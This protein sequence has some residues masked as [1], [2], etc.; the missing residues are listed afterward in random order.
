MKWSDFSLIQN[1]PMFAPGYSGK[2][3]QKNPEKVS[4]APADES[5]GFPIQHGLRQIYFSY[6]QPLVKGNTPRLKSGQAFRF[7]TNYDI[8]LR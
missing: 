3:K 1:Y 8:L 2:N 5:I 6:L 4:F 7:N